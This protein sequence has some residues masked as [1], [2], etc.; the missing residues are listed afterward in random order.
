[1]FVNTQLFRTE[2]LSF[3]KNGYY[4]PYPR[5][6][7]GYKDYWDEQTKRCIEGYE[8]GGV[9]ITG[10][11]YAY[12][13]F[14]KIERVP[15]GAKKVNGKTRKVMSFPDFWDGDFEYFWE[16]EF[17]KNNHQH[18]IVAKSRRKG[19]SFKNAFMCAHQYNFERNSRAIIG[20][21]IQDYANN[22][23]VS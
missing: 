9:K 22:T 4:C 13:N 1:M 16:V 2:A 21:Y 15:E 23:M 12:L 7:A 18:L 17:A 5:G 6:T 8:V 3:L 20:A 10:L 14:A 11:H 19:F